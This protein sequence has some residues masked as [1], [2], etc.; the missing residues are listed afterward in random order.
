MPLGSALKMRS[1]PRFETHVTKR[2]P[3]KKPA[4]KRRAPAKKKE[5]GPTKAS[6]L[7]DAV[8]KIQGKYGKHAI[9]KG[10]DIPPIRRL[11]TGILGV[12]VALG[13][14]DGEFGFP[15]GRI[16]LVPGYESACKSTTCFMA[17]ARAQQWGWP[18][19]LIE[20][21]KGFDP[22]WASTMGVD[23]DKLMVEPSVSMEQSLD[24]TAELVRSMPEGL[25]VVDSLASM[26]PSDEVDSSFFEWQ[27][28]LAARINNKFFRVVAS[29]ANKASNFGPEYNGPTMLVCQQYRSNIKTGSSKVIPGGVGQ[30]FAGSAILNLRA[31]DP[32]YHVPGKGPQTTYPKKGGPKGT[33][34]VGKSFSYNVSKNKTA[35]P[36]RAGEFVLYTM[37]HTDADTGHRYIA[38]TV[39]YYDQ[40][41]SL[42]Q[43]DGVIT[44][45]GSWGWLG[46]ERLGNGADAIVSKLRDSDILE[47]V[48]AGIVAA[49]ELRARSPREK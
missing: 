24:I 9:R 36:H 19:V 18:T 4:A 27:Q 39:D 17:I 8:A 22:S 32:V 16:T 14:Y 43:L 44:M 31:R 20:A 30:L 46:D 15:V 25:I 29:G 34:I 38:G 28:G 10:S 41:Y 48:Y 49:E 3:A 42:A 1:A 26:S 35:P 40:V 37:N 6:M 11:P 47:K 33:L 12:D 13:T 21:E 5:E 23:L 2:T 45:K 7:A